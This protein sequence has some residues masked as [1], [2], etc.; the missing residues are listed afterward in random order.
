[1]LCH[2]LLGDLPLEREEHLFVCLGVKTC[3][4]SLA[5]ELSVGSLFNRVEL[6]VLLQLIKG[7]SL[8]LYHVTVCEGEVIDSFDGLHADLIALPLRLLV[9]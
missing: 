3:L 9:L 1:M 8:P 4:I 5:L 7:L 6:L 2:L